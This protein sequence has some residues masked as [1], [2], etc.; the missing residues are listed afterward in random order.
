MGL[1]DYTIYDIICRNARLYP[2]NDSIVFNENRLSHQEFKE[3]CDK[4]SAGLVK[5]NVT[6]GDRLGIIAHNSDEFMILYGAAAKIGAIVLPV[7]WRLQQEEIENVLN[8]CMP[9][10]IFAGSEYHEAVAEASSKVK[11]IEGIC[12]ISGDKTPDGFIPFKEIYLEDD[13]GDAPDVSID[14][15]FVIIPT[16]AVSGR[17]RGALLSHG[18]IMVYNM[19]QT[20]HFAL[21]SKD[22]YLCSLPLFHVAG[23]FQI[24]AIMYAGGKNV[25]L[26]QFDPALSLQ[27]MEKE[28]VTTYIQFP[29]MLKK[30]LDQHKKTPHNLSSLRNM[31]GIDNFEALSEIAP[32]LRHS[33]FYG[34]TECLPI[35]GGFI[36]ERPGSVGRPFPQV[37][38]AVFDD[39]DQ[40]VPVG[41]PGE[42]CVRSPA[43]FQGYWGLEEE[44]AYTFKNNWHHTGDIGRLDE[45]GFL[46]YVKRKADKELIKPGG[47]NVYPVEVEKVILG[48]ETVEEVSVIGVEDS[49]YGESIKAIC[50]LKQGHSLGSEEIIDFVASKIA[51]YKKP[52]YVVFVKAL[53]KTVDGE[54]DR[55]QV[56][57]D[58]GA[59]Y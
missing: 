59:I 17:A 7:N 22:C 41:A 16:A 9:K 58:H 31:I 39:Y 25:I 5:L 21:N 56:K 30:L 43:V 57:K 52:K 46:W 45:D 32:N 6:L 40:E 13:K 24:M 10:L 20:N 37:K 38:V 55:E 34:Q 19:T 8:D 15:G 33:T 35:S 1:R 54:I 28:K 4:L 50:V 23:L 26:E 42:I 12:T 47:E 44:N 3:K 27:L 36:D 53:P 29:P 51:R 14:S 18:N 48:H 11:S 2:D 49:Y